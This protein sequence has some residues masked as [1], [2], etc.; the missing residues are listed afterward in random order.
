MIVHLKE[1]SPLKIEFSLWTKDAQRVYIRKR[2]D[3]KNNLDIEIK[4][5]AED[6]YV[7][8]LDL[9]ANKNWFLTVDFFDFVVVLNDGKEQFVSM[10]EYG[11]IDGVEYGLNKIFKLKPYKNLKGNLSFKSYTDVELREKGINKNDGTIDLD[12]ELPFEDNFGVYLLE[13]ELAHSKEIYQFATEVAS[14]KEVNFSV[15][16]SLLGEGIP[17]YFTTE[18]P[19]VN[20]WVR[21]YYYDELLSSKTELLV[22]ETNSMKKTKVGTLLT[23]EQEFSGYK[24]TNVKVEKDG[25]RLKV[26]SDNSAAEVYVKKRNNFRAP[27]D[28]TVFVKLDKHKNDYVLKFD[29][30]RFEFNLNEDRIFDFYYVEEHDK[31]TFMKNLIFDEVFEKEMTTFH[32]SDYS[33]YE[34]TD[35]SLALAV[36][37]NYRDSPKNTVKLGIIG[38]C[39]SRVGFSNKAYFNPGY[40]AKY[41]IV[42]TIFHSTA[43][44]L[45]SPPLDVPYRQLLEVENETIRER[46]E[47]EFSKKHLTKMKE[48]KA[49]FLI[50]DFF[51]EVSSE[52]VKIQENQ[53]LTNNIQMKKYK[54]IEEANLVGEIVTVENWEVRKA[55]FTDLLKEFIQE[56]KKIVPEERIILMKIKL[57]EN[58]YT[59]E[60]TKERYIPK[61]IETIT[62]LN[63]KYSMIEDLFIDCLPKAKIINLGDK[64]FISDK[65]FPLGA[66]INHFESAYYKEFMTRLDT[67]VIREL[68]KKKISR[69]KK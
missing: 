4:E 34:T 24:L 40:F 2:K 58:Y 32:N 28:G 61:E 16:M 48:K 10:E 46:I 18:H 31:K 30:F 22:T 25:I 15:D 49:D 6:K 56:L 3:L 54:I 33:I 36:K 64:N 63:E 55:I 21:V 65:R 14:S 8:I 59:K 35:H 45:I 67:I 68:T 47:L 39:F 9:E 19:V 27:V 11:N 17:I 26:L 13:L 52:I 41:E 42:D 7:G 38:S 53:Y 51:A 12:F 69:R 5:I 43:A 60:G 37:R 66:S 20:Y 29:D 23:F 62:Q 1:I 44:S 50:I 57:A